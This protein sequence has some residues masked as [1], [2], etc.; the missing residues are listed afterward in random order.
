M[1]F[2]TDS[3]LVDPA[4]ALGVVAAAKMTESEYEHVMWR[5]AAKL[6]GI[7]EVAA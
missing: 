1:L 6:F 5:N 4:I 7:D 3:T 2:G